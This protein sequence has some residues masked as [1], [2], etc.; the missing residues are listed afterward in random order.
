[1]RMMVF[2]HRT[3]RWHPWHGTRLAWLKLP[4]AVAGSACALS[5]V[6]LLALSVQ[7]PAARQPHPPVT[8]TAPADQQ[9]GQQ[10]DTTVLPSNRSLATG[11]LDFSG[12]STLLIPTPA[13]PPNRSD[14]PVPPP[15]PGATLLFPNAPPPQNDPPGTDPPAG[16]A[17]PI[18]DPPGGPP[19]SVP[20]PPGGPPIS[21]PDPPGGQPTPVPEPGSL[22]LL[23]GAVFL[24]ASMRRFGA[25]RPVRHDAAGR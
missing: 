4:H 1:M 6:A 20:D 2:D 25:P 7:T 11:P 16:P 14:P 13:P 22:G 24:L 17:T 19:I 8:P 12:G 15:E 5:T 18:P 9:T 10:P 3:C 23:A 21:V